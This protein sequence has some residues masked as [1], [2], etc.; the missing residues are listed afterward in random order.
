MQAKHSGILRSLTA[1]RGE[2]KKNVG[3]EIAVGDVLV[4]DYFT[5]QDGGQVRVEPIAKAVIECVFEG[6]IEA[7]S[8][9]QAFA[10]A[11]LEI[12]CTFEVQ[13]LQQTVTAV[14]NKEGLFHVKICY[15]ATETINF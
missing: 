12:A 3:E 7:E 13:I 1:L 14:E 9:Q 6:E 4:E 5:K 11:Y 10:V 2:A 8:V 15:L